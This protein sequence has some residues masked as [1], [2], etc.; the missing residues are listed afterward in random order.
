MLLVKEKGLLIYIIK[1]CQRIE[2]TVKETTKEEFLENNLFKD[3]ICF[4]LLQ[5]GELAKKFDPNFVKEYGNAPW[6]KIKGMRDIIVHGYGTVVFSKIWDTATND[7]VPLH[8]YCLKI[9][10]INPEVE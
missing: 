4:N 9:I 5:I 2:E 1:H 6:K 3:S 8:E 7:I 10:E